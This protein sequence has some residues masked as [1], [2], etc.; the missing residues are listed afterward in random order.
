MFIVLEGHDGVG[1]TTQAA[2]LEEYLTKQ[3][4]DVVR[5][6]TPG[7]SAVADQLRRIAIYGDGVDGDMRGA[8][9]H[10]A[11]KHTFDNV[12]RPA[13][14]K[15][16]VVIADRWILSGYIYQVIGDEDGSTRFK[17][18]NARLLRKF[19]IPYLTFVLT[20]DESVRKA[21]KNKLL[22]ELIKSGEKIPQMEQAGDA[23][24]NRIAKALERLDRI[25][26]KYSRFVA[27]IN[28]TGLSIGQV[29]EQIQ[30]SLNNHL[31]GTPSKW[32][33]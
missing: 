31:Q 25:P 2:L 13:L 1:K 12:I 29:A 8:L 19:N 24:E 3:G 4:Y 21:R 16:K 23:Y 17:Y 15:G 27:E 6:S 30:F 10:A 14:K 9:M 18:I 7:G 22:K 26:I 5:I 20:L 33:F 28:T 11:R 32:A